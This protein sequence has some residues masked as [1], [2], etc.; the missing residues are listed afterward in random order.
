MNLQAEFSR[1]L[2]SLLQAGERQK[3]VEVTCDADV[4]K[5]SLVELDSIGCAFTELEY[6][7]THLESLSPQQLRRLGKRFAEKVNYLM[8]PIRAIEF[9]L[10]ESTLQL[11]SVRPQQHHSGR[12]Y[13]EIL[14]RPS[15]LHLCRYE[16]TAGQKRQRVPA[17]LTREV[18]VRLVGDLESISK[19]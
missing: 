3:R 4:I 10:E 16:K 11:R 14:A 8:E 6:W 15:A 19:N 7:G 17:Q 13:Y 18:L 12:R 1:V 2:D 5:I 9:D